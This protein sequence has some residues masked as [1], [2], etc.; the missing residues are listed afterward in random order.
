MALVGVSPIG[1]IVTTATALSDSVVITD[2]GQHSTVEYACLVG[3]GLYQINIVVPNLAAGDYP[4]AIQLQGVAAD[5]P[6]N[7]PV[8]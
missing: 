1:V 4:V 5:S 3:D 6:P 7:L 2:G 8:R